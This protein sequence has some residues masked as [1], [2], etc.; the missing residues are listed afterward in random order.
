MPRNPA[1]LLAECNMNFRMPISRVVVGDLE[2]EPGG[3]VEVAFR[4][5]YIMV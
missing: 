4:P 1:E 2:L 3:A 5:E